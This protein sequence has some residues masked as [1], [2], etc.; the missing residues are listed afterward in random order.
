M[1]WTLQV[2]S[3]YSGD[4]V[5]ET[6]LLTT[7]G[8]ASTLATARRV[9]RSWRQ[10]DLSERIALCDAWLSVLDSKIERYAMELSLQMGKP[11]NEARGEIRTA[12]DRARQLIGLAPAALAAESLPDKA[13][14]I[15]EIHKDPVG[16][17]LSIVAWNYP[18]LI[19]VNAVIPAVLV[20][21]SFSKHPNELGAGDALRVLSSKRAPQRL[22]TKCA[23]LS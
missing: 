8:V 14:F 4:I 18:F 19:G 3:P 17:V 10:T 9:H 5:F 6:G 1:V 7:A 20:T 13:G 22:S 11:I 16:V 23:L 21:Q 2:D 12:L 15:R